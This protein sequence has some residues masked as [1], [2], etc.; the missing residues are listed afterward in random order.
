MIMPFENN[1]SDYFGSIN[2]IIKYE[3]V[4]FLDKI[5]KIKP[6]FEESIFLHFKINEKHI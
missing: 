5:V 1:I 3:I 4:K 6:H 2:T